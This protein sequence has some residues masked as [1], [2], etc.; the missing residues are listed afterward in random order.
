MQPFLLLICWTQLVSIALASRSHGKFS[1]SSSL[2]V[3]SLSL[4]CTPQSWQTRRPSRQSQLLVARVRQR[5]RTIAQRQLHSE[6][7]LR[8]RNH[9]GK[10]GKLNDDVQV[11]SVNNGLAKNLLRGAFLRVASD[12]SGGIPLECIKTQVSCNTDLGPVEAF[13]KVVSGEQGLWALWAGT[14]SRVV[15]GALM[16]GIFLIA[17]QAVKTRALV[18]GLPPTMAAL[19]GGLVGGLAQSIVMTPCSLL[20]TSVNLHRGKPG[21]ESASSVARR[22]IQENGIA[23]MYSGLGPMALRQ[24]TNWAS[25]TTFTEIARTSL[26]MS[27]YGMLGEIGSGVFGGICACWN[28]PIETV[29]VLTQRDFSGGH[30]PKPF[31]TYVN[32]V[33]EENG[34][35]GL[36]RGVSV[37][38]VQA[39]WQTVF[40]VVVPNI[41]GI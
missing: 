16:G 24:A 23:G 17:S 40:M 14:E 20:F 7:A 38:S 27:Q 29:R 9:P 4:H 10:S 35:Q 18:M 33:V 31:M 19:A 11:C 36:F 34:F 2:P 6:R 3:E 15:E 21:F 8:R 37:R 26:K 22:I 13:R 25:R 32:D 28:T 41:M 30:T 39:V 1:P 12:L 5:R